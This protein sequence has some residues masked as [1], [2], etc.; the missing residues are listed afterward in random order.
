MNARLGLVLAG[1]VVFAA[2][3]GVGTWVA[4][5]LQT[6]PSVAVIS[7]VPTPT[8]PP[9][10]TREPTLAE[11]LDAMNYAEAFAVARTEMADTVNTESPGTAVFAIWAAD[12]LAWSDIA[13]TTDETSNALAK[14]DSDVARGKRLCTSGTVQQITVDKSVAPKHLAV[15]QMDN[16]NG[17]FYHF[18]A[19]RSTGALVE[20]SWAR[21]CGVVTGLYSFSNLAGGTTISVAIVGMFDLPENRNVAPTVIARP[22]RAVVSTPRPPG[23]LGPTQLRY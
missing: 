7:A 4:V 22:G 9:I 1:L 6:S 23:S 5:T 16:G 3:V 14:K 17:G 2:L 11:R 20:E 13:V 15:G 18:A 8:P 19:V 10:P 12:H 21:F